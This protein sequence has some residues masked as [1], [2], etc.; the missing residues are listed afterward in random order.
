[1]HLSRR[2]ILP[3]LGIL[4]F[5]FAHFAQNVWHLFH[6]DDIARALRNLD[7]AGIVTG[8]AILGMIEAT[9]V[10]C[11][12]VPGTAVIIV[13]LIGMQPNIG[14]ALPLLAGLMFGTLAGYGLSLLLGRLL[15]QRLPSLVGEAYFHR[16]QSLTERY[17]AMAFAVGAFHPNQLALGFAILGFFRV[18]RSWRYFVFAAIAQA[19]WWGLYASAASL[20]SGQTIISSSNFQLYVAGAFAI[21]LVYELFFARPPQVTGPV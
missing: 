20:I 1:M 11:F 21:W 7:L 15:Q 18:E 17:G 6:V 9:I 13:L 16:V 2:L 8:I 3:A 19:A 4:V 12:Y 14:Q 10:V 5:V